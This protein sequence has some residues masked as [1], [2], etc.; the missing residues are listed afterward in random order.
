MLESGKFPQPNKLW[1]SNQAGVHSI[2]RHLYWELNSAPFIAFLEQ[3]TGIT[4]LIPDPHFAGGGVH[5]TLRD[6]LLMIHAD[7]NKHP[8]FDLDRRLNILIY[9]NEDW[10][11]DEEH[12]RYLIYYF[13]PKLQKAHHELL[14]LLLLPL[15][16]WSNRFHPNWR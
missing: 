6:G 15:M 5:E 8:H 7:F 1:L 14:P 4:S 2:I 11:D 13:Q 9:L 12:Y 10:Q 3:L 16:L